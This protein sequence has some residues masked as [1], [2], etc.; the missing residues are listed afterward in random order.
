MIANETTIRQ[1]AKEV[2]V[3]NYR[4]LYGIWQRD[5]LKQFNQ[6]KNH[7]KTYCLIHIK[8]MF[9]KQIWEP[10]IKTE[11]LVNI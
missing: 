5:K 3:S 10:T 2:D 8:T 7:E 9:V 6:L 4:Q 11:Y 1:S